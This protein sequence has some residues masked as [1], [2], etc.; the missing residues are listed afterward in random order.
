[1]GL[2][3]FTLGGCGVAVLSVWWVLSRMDDPTANDLHLHER[4]IFY[5]SMGALLL[6][7]QFLSVGILAELITA[8]YGRDSSSYSIRQTTSQTA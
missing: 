6:G 2:I 5:Y 4:A 8:F 1:L 7:G 3:G